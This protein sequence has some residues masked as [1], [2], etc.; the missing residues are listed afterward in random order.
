MLRKHGGFEEFKESFMTAYPVAGEEEKFLALAPSHLVVQDKEDH[1][2]RLAIDYTTLNAFF[3]KATNMLSPIETKVL[4]MRSYKYLVGMDISKQY[5]MVLNQHALSQCILHRDHPNDVYIHNGLIMGHISSSSLA[6]YCMIQTGKLFDDLLDKARA[7][8]LDY[9]K[10][11]APLS[12]A[13]REGILKPSSLPTSLSL[14][15]L[16][17]D[18]LYADNLIICKDSSSDLVKEAVALILSLNAYSFK[19]HELFSNTIPELSLI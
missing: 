18:S 17:R 12:Y 3:S 10:I 19:V 15:K 6:G 11:Y 9:D 5:H 2:V 4:E 1:P 7:Q 16:I 13:L 14:E 8:T